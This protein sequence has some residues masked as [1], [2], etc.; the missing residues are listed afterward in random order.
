MNTSAAVCLSASSLDSAMIK[1]SSEG[2]SGELLS[3]QLT[4]SQKLLELT[5]QSARK[6]QE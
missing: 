6:Y 5:E 4:R 1:M 2:D 3:P